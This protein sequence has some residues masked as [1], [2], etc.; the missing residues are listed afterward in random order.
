M[1]PFKF[2]EIGLRNLCTPNATLRALE[3]LQKAT[4][5]NEVVLDLR[6]CIFSY[7]LSQILEKIVDKLTSQVINKKITIYYGYRSK[8]DDHM[9][10]Y[11]ASKVGYIPENIT[12]IRSLIAFLKDKYDIDLKLIGQCNG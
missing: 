8:D 5:D 10:P 12:D 3:Y 7:S 4:I 11:L 1:T 9:F 2:K 6:G